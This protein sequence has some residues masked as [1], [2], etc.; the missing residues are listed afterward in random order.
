MKIKKLLFGILSCAVP[1]ILF[2]QDSSNNGKECWISYSYHV[3]MS[4]GGDPTMTLYITSDVNTNY[5]VEIYGVLTI[6]AGSITAGQVVTAVIPTSYFIN[7]EGAF[8]GRTV[9]V[10]TDKN[11]VVYAYIT[12]NA[13]SGATVCLPTTVLGKEYYSANFTQVSNEANSYSYFTIIA[14]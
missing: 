12:R 10:S 14:V 3:G 2:C 11:S 1:A 8:T 6:Q 9:R 4:Q 7:D 5:T 13:V